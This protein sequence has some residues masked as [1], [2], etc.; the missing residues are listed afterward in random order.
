MPLIISA[1]VTFNVLKI[2]YRRM[3]HH[4]KTLI[5]LKKK[6]HYFYSVIMQRVEPLMSLV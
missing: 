3:P 2:I 1:A 5:I 6:N 4:S